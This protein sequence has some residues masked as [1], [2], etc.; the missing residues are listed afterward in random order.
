[1]VRDHLEGF[2][3]GARA[4]SAHGFGVPRHVERELR[5]YLTCGVL[6]HGS[7]RV[8]CGDCGCDRLLAFPCKVGRCARRAPVGAWPTPP[9]TWWTACITELPFLPAL[10]VRGA[11]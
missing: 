5:T 11:F 4:R 8:R 10:G 9:P 1:M 6:A 7:V 2:L 3:A